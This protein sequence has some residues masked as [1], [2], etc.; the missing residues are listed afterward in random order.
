MTPSGAR[1]EIR[2]PRWIEYYTQSTIVCIIWILWFFGPVLDAYY[3]TRESKVFFL[4]FAFNIHYRLR[5]VSIYEW[6]SYSALSWQWGLDRSE[7]FKLRSPA[8]L[9]QGPRL[10]LK[11]SFHQQVG[12]GT[13]LCL[14]MLWEVSPSSPKYVAPCGHWLFWSKKCHR[15]ALISPSKRQKR[16]RGP[17][18]PKIRPFLRVAS[19]NFLNSQSPLLAK[20]PLVKDTKTFLSDSFFG[21]SNIPGDFQFGSWGE[22]WAVLKLSTVLSPREKYQCL[23]KSGEGFIFVCLRPPN[24]AQSPEASAQLGMDQTSWNSRGIKIHFWFLSK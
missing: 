15:A 5:P 8:L 9:R 3:D 17:D 7:Q 19:P 11:K 22:V 2:V 23:S 6:S 24:A 18:R 13:W 10:T 12:R 1:P 20:P 4:I 14:A 21:R 16:H